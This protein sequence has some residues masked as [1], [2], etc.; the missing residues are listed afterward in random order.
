MARGERKVEGGEG[1]KGALRE[2]V[3]A[4]LSAAGAARFPGA[5]GRIPNF[6]GAEAAARRLATTP[7]WQA[8]RTVKAN[9]DAPQ[10]LA[11]Q[12]ALEAGKTVF[13]AVPRLTTKAPFLALE[14]A[15]LRLRGVSAR[16]ASTIGGAARHGRPVRPD[17]MEAVDLILCGSVAVSRDGARVGKGGGYS[18]LE[19]ALAREIGVVGEATPIVTLVHPVQIVEPGAIPMTRHDIPVDWIVT[20]DE[21]I[22]TRTRYPRPAGVYAE[23]LPAAKRAAIPLLATRR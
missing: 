17:E 13:M 11:R 8:A 20:S 5:R 7:L 19:Y 22:E 12:L 16:E 15:R 4:A 6:V 10:R 1:P 18:D 2:R 3:W 21:A 14:P 9:P 23:D